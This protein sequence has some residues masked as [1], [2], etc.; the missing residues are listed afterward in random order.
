MKVVFNGIM[1]T[2]ESG[3]VPCG[4]GGTSTRGFQASEWLMLPSGAEKEF[5]KGKPVDVSDYDGEWLLSLM[6]ADQNGDMQHEFSK[7]E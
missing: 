6:Y 7:V 4:H 3:C 5:H 2:I 1:K